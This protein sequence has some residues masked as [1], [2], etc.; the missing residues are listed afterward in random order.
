MFGLLKLTTTI[1][2]AYTFFTQVH[3]SPLSR[4][5]VV[6]PHITSPDAN[7]VW[8]IGTT[9]LVTWDTSD[10]PPDSQITNPIGQIILGYNESNSLNLDFTNPLA[11]GFKLRDGKVQIT[12]PN[13]PPR[14]DYLIVLFGDSGNTSPSFAITA[15]TGS[16]SLAA[17]PQPSTSTSTD[18]TSPPFTGSVITGGISEST[19]TTTLD[20]STTVTVPTSTTSGSSA[21]SSSVSGSAASASASTTSQSSAAW[22]VHRSSCLFKIS[23]WGM[24]SLVLLA[25]FF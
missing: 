21:S 23:S 13:V 6:A 11:K 25:L 15:I 3:A 14:T 19:T 18:W 2:F 22:S 1:C 10:L 16:G 12:V 17:T 8:P 9:Q 4:R 20:S 5:D 24:A 7:S